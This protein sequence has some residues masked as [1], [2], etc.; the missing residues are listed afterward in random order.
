MVRFAWVLL[1]PTLLVASLVAPAQ[2]QPEVTTQVPPAPAG[3]E[4]PV[5]QSALPGGLVVADAAVL[6]AGRFGLLGLAGFGY[7]D[8]VLAEGDRLRRGVASLGLSYA[9]VRSFAFGLSLDGRYDSHSSGDDGYVGDPRLFLRLALGN[10]RLSYG[11]QLAVWVP[12]K[13]AP[14]FAFD[15][16]SVEARALLSAALGPAMAS[17]NLGARLDNSAS[18]VDDPRSLSPQD[19]VSLGVSDYHA[20]L[21]GARV[22]LPLG[23]GFVSAEAATELYLGDG[24]PDATVRALVSAGVR[25]A[26][27]VSL[28]GFFQAA[29]A[30]DAR[31][32]MMAQQPVPLVPYETAVTFG[33]G[34]ETRFGGE[35]P[36]PARRVTTIET[37]AQPEPPAQPKRAE[38]SGAVLDDA[39]APVAGAKVELVRDGKVVAT[40]ATDAKGKYQ[41][42]DL[43]PGAAT[44]R[45]AMPGKEP[46]ETPVELV[47]GANAAPKVQL[48]P[49]LPPGE[50]RGNVR[51]RAGGKPIAGAAVSV[52]PGGYTSTTGADGSFA[53]EVPPGKYTIT[54]T[55]DGYLPQQIEAVVDQ[56]GVTVKFINLDKP[57]K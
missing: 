14:S 3:A 2:A 9:P 40:S 52:A 10:Q 44:L 31:A 5:G 37:P 29:T 16:T 30:P 50:L 1:V 39:G 21:V 17:L 33:L 15:A 26:P 25:I 12:G 49:E 35:A 24:A 13:E 57:K 45:V 54:T 6:P 34:L 23:R 19:Q 28:L 27:T 7:R 43:A 42:P 20:A 18:S 4:S 51:T 47:A 53:F 48:D 11:A 8:E 32:A 38:L 22:S 46:H 36:A 41:L 56:D 55:A